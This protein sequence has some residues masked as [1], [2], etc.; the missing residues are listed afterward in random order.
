MSS[1]FFHP[2]VVHIPIALAVLMPV[3]SAGLLLAWHRNWLPNRSWFVAV[4]L[5]L[6]LV[7]SGLLA[8]RTGEQEEE[9]VE[10]V[11]P[12]RAIDSHEEA[13]EMFVWAS[14]AVLLLML[15][16]LWRAEKQEGPILA[17]VALAGTLLVLLLGY[18]TGE[19]GGALVYEH[20][21]ADVYTGGSSGDR[22]YRGG[23]DE[24]DD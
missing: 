11:V 7:A 21:A 22:A 16:A 12:E 8:L 10:E 2:K 9:R 18:R 14:G 1:L 24:D 4:L 6:I 13:A 5:Q 3:V 20:G 23:Y 19:A 17:G 15:G